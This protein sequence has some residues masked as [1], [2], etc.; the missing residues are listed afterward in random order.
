MALFLTAITSKAELTADWKLHM[1]FDRWATDIIDTPDRVYFTA[2]TFEENANLTERSMAS[3]SLFC[4]DKQS[5]E[6]TSIN[7]RN[8]GSGN[9]VACM[10]YNPSAHYLLVVYTDCNIDFIYDDGRVFNLPALKMASIPGKKEANRITFDYPNKTALIA[11]TFGYITLNQEKHEVAESRNYGVNL[12]CVAHAGENMV[13]C[14]DGKVYY[15]PFA[16]KRFNFDDYTP[17]EGT[18]EKNLIVTGYNG[19]NFFAMKKGY[20]SVIDEFIFDPETKTFEVKMKR[21]DPQIISVQYINDGGQR[22]CGNVSFFEVNASGIFKPGGRRPSDDFRLPAATW[23]AKTI[24]CLSPQKGIRSY[25]ASDENN[26][27]FTLTHDF[28]RPN[29]PAVYYSTST[30]YHPKYGLICGANA[31]DLAYSNFS[32]ETPANI[33]ALKNGFW[34]EYGYTYAENNLGSLSNFG[35]LAIDPL[36]TDVAYLSSTINGLMRVNLANPVDIMVMANPSNRYSSKDYF[37]KFIDDAAAWRYNC[38]FSPPKFSADNTMWT[39]HFDP[40]APGAEL[41][42]WP[43]ADRLASTS[44]STFRPLKKI[45]VP[46]FDA[47]NYDVMTTLTQ[48]KN[49]IA[50]GGF[51]NY[52]TMVFYDH[53]GTPDNT[54]DDKYVHMTKFYDQ[55]GGGVSF[56][57]VNNLVEDPATGLVWILSQRG[58]FTINPKTAFENPTLVNRIKVARNDGTNL[59]DYLLNEINVNHMSID[60]EGRKW[61]S[62]SN[63]LVCTSQDGRTILGEFTTDNSYLPGNNVFST[64]YNPENNSIMVATD[65]GLVEMFPSGSGMNTDGLESSMRVYPNPVEPDFYG[66]VRID[67]IADG[68]LVKITDAKGGLVKELGM[69]EGGSVQWDASGMNGSRVATGVYYVMVSPGN[70]GNGKTQISKILI[71]N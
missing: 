64:C 13:V 42:Y 14:H 9:A 1:P 49:I 6:V 52:G 27:E 71:L 33:S 21:E 61:F 4:Y 67:N 50:I 17:V 26:Y 12:D 44:P 37:V 68:S 55:D 46:E 32:Q 11:T 25:R 31:Y 3:N 63:G 56:L 43:A 47:S 57:A 36:N 16:D 35:G 38:R 29:A 20:D 5:D 66:W 10:A 58:V 22:I 24:W 8:T 40:D 34:K 28:I 19:N 51:N 48:N 41:W 23:D 7:H 39:L 54:S 62:T 2:R 59:A 69:A 53:N 30:V 18:T 70:N 60:G 15:A 65:G 45:K